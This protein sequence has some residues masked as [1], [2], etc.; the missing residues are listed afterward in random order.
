MSA[1]IVPGVN[2]G[3]K[4]A[5]FSILQTPYKTVDGHAIRA[6]IVI[7]KSLPTGRKAPVIARF[8]GGGLVGSLHSNPT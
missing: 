1:G 5:R 8:H 2:F 4:F 7:P 6:D 3:A